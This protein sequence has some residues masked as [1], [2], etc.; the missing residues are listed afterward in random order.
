MGRKEIGPERRR[1]ARRNWSSS[2]VPKPP[3]PS[4]GVPRSPLP[5]EALQGLRRDLPRRDLPRRRTKRGIEFGNLPEREKNR[6]L[7]VGEEQEGEN[8]GGRATEWVWIRSMMEATRKK[9]T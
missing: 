2:S 8:P 7:A 3:P 5:R 1:N 4:P 6:E 9:V